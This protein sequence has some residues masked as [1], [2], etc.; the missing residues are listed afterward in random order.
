MKAKKREANALKL[1]EN[2]LQR[3]KLELEEN[4]PQASLEERE[5][6]GETGSR[7]GNEEDGSWKCASFDQPYARNPGTC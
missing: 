7:R 1:K 2:N 5:T 4:A 6:L 3:E